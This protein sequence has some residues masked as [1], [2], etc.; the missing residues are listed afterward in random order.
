[1]AGKT[2][3]SQVRNITAAERARGVIRNEDLPWERRDHALFV[4]YAPYDN[5]AMR[6]GGGGT[7]RRR[8]HG[9]CAHC[10]RHHASG[11]VQRDPA[12]GRPIP[13]GTSATGSRPSSN[14]SCAAGTC[15]WPHRLGGS[16]MSYLEYTVKTR[17][18][19]A[20]KILHL[21]WPLVL[22]LMAMASVGFLMLYSVAGGGS[23]VGPSRR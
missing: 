18:R 17:A 13:R 8:V 19:G 2:G 11:A 7:W 4:A 20:G 21:N 23:A 16:R 5:R 3:T 22:L 9:R 10:A 12:A 14:R 15:R 1:M 6:G